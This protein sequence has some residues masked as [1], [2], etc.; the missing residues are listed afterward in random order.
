MPDFKSNQERDDYFFQNADYFTLVK[1]KVG[2]PDRTEYKTMAEAES[3][4][5]TRITIGGGRYMIY[6]VIGNE[7][8][9]V[10]G[11]SK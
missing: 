1:A 8:A 2:I 6:A 7:S 4:A 3:A 10:K 9:F 5:K 11:V